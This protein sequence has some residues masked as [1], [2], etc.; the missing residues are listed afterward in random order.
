MPRDF[1]PVV[2]DRFAL[3]DEVP[4][5][6]TWELVQSRMLDESAGAVDETANPM[7]FEP[8]VGAGSRRRWSTLARAGGFVAAAAAVMVA[9]LVV[10]QAS[11]HESTPTLGS[12]LKSPDEVLSPLVSLR[13][14]L[15]N[16]ANVEMF[17]V[18]SDTESY[19]RLT[20]LPE[21]D[22]E[23]WG[24][25]ESELEY[26]GDLAEGTREG[27][28]I[29]QEIEVQALTGSL[30]P[31]APEPIQAS[32]PADE[33][34]WSAALGALVLTTELAPG[35]RFEI[36]SRSPDHSPEQ[37]REAT[38]EDPPG[39]SFTNLPSTL[40]TP[41]ADTAREVT[42]GARSSYEAALLLQAWFQR[43][44]EYSLEVQ[45]GHGYS[46]LEDLLRTRVGY[47]EQFASAFAVLARTLGIPSQV[48]VGFTPGELRSDGWYSVSG[49]HAH[50]WPEI[51]F[52]DLGWVPFEPTPGRSEP[53]TTE[54]V[55]ATPTVPATALPGSDGSGEGIGSSYVPLAS[56]DDEGLR[57][58][59]TLAPEDGDI[60]IPTAPATWSL[61]PVVNIHPSDEHPG[62]DFV[63]VTSPASVD[64]V[65]KT[66]KVAVLPIC[67]GTEPDC[68]ANS[69]EF[70]VAPIV[71]GLVEVGGNEWGE[72]TGCCPT[73]TAVFGDF[74]IEILDSPPTPGRSLLND[75]EIV[76]FIAGLRVGSVADL[77][78]QITAF[79]SVARTPIDRTD[80]EGP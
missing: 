46:A 76:E 36:V 57:P 66:L 20:T 21:F 32:S 74:F 18:R 75:P 68:G 5:P 6:D 42:A 10:D 47:S 45:P 13:S 58:L 17:R 78:A 26:T 51:W 61:A 12:N 39:P 70:P 72:Q 41:L 16:G 60:V 55:P 3:F 71:D 15:T 49:G 35:D 56:I 52:D 14:Q 11:R 79:D 25:P 65:T 1:D 62:H 9:L 69:V 38:T 22:G 40:P 8:L 2:A 44:F 19:W 54:S 30:V 23:V 50:A 7:E 29:R 77:P 48:A 80:D 33:L 28:E 67:N 63:I 4:V 37:L 24:V 73:A 64:G 43:E 59:D 27:R 53:P 34:R 31:V